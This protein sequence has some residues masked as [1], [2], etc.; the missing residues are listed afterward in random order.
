M[1]LIRPRAVIGGRLFDHPD[2]D[3]NHCD[4]VGQWPMAAPSK[5][6]EGYN[7]QYHDPGTGAD[8][9][10]AISPGLTPDFET[11]FRFNLPFLYTPN[12]HLSAMGDSSAGAAFSAD[13]TIPAKFIDTDVNR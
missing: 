12:N 2:L 3:F 6:L 8:T 7:W 11:G 5:E 1:G 9:D 10:T 13:L 4:F